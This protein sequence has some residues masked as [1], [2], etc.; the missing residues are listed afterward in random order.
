MLTRSHRLTGWNAVKSRVEQLNLKMTDEQVSSLLGFLPCT[1]RLAHTPQVKDATA[2]IKELAD[3]RTQSMEDVDSI[4]R[5]YH[6]AVHAGDLQ[7]GQSEKLDRLLEKV[8]WTWALR[9]ACL[10]VGRYKGLPS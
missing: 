8:S 1:M 10:L 4:L 6:N 9:G 2:K 7:V 5:I 3:V